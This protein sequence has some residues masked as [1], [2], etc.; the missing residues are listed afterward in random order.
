M[1]E[2]LKHQRHHSW[3][4]FIVTC[5]RRWPAQAPQCAATQ[6]TG[7]AAATGGMLDLD[8]LVAASRQ[9]AVA[10][11]I[12]DTD[13][14]RLPEVAA[15]AEH[16]LAGIERQQHKLCG[17][18]AA[19]GSLA[20]TLED[21]PQLAAQHCELLLCFR[22]F[23]NAAAA[24]PCAKDALLSAGLLALVGSTLDL[25]ASAAIPLNWQLPASVAQT[26]ANL[27]TASRSAAAAAWAALFPLRF[28]MLA[29]IAGRMRGVG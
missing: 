28:S 12:L 24:G 3:S 29:H 9:A 8:A 22:I 27:C 6:S 5:R 23:R 19:T 21:D 1:L 20:P 4:A 15:H 10:G 26:L 11:G 2:L 17:D 18:C 13:Q 16:L 25:L 14:L 7:A